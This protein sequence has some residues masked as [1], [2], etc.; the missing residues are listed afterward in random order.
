MERLLNNCRIGV[1]RAVSGYLYRQLR[2]IVTVCRASLRGQLCNVHLMGMKQ[3]SEAFYQ[4]RRIVNVHLDPYGRRHRRTFVCTGAFH[5]NQQFQLRAFLRQGG[6]NQRDGVPAPR[7]KHDKRELVTEHGQT[8][9]FNITT[10][11]ADLTGNGIDDTRTIRTEG[12]DNQIVLLLLRQNCA[13]CHAWEYSQGKHKKNR[14]T[15][16][17]NTLIACFCSG[18]KSTMSDLFVEGKVNVYGKY[19]C[20]GYAD[21]HQRCCRSR[22]SEKTD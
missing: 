9:V 17:Y 7:K 22:E 15:S 10:A 2:R 4:M 14:R 21:G 5:H 8:A 18:V 3:V 12:G 13:S 16:A 6:F 1:R 11:T 19:C 20:T